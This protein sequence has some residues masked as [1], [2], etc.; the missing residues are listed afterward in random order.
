MSDYVLCIWSSS[1]ANGR[2]NLLFG[3]DTQTWGFKNFEPDYAEPNRW[4]LFGHDHSNGSP[5]LDAVAWQAGTVD[6][7]LCEFTTP[8]YRGQA[9]HWPDEVEAGEVIYPHRFG[10]TPVASIA[11]TPAAP[12]ALL[13]AAGTEALRLAAI[14]NRGV[15][16]DID[17][18]PLLAA[19]GVQVVGN[20]VPDLSRTAGVPRP[21]FPPVRGKRGLGRSHDPEFNSAVERRAVE[22]AT[23][24]LLAQGW[25][26]V[27]PLGKP[28]DL[29]CTKRTGEEKHVEVKGASGAG[30]DVQY[31]PNEVRHFRTCPHGADLIVVRD[32]AVD[33]DVR[34]YV[35][36]GGQLLHVENYTAPAEDLQA[37][38]WLGRVP[39][40][41][42]VDDTGEELT[43]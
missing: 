3:L 11:G 21:A 7:V 31:T 29:V 13:G 26:E 2:R 35:A 33:R 39:G 27:R 42:D 41:G 15:R 10:L 36:T 38:G 30:A 9:P 19:M 37:T 34:P 4:V 43:A 17:V 24:H 14:G 28:F 16:V 8:L 18:H 40:W 25:D 1:S 22:M 5:R 6:L 12:T 32:I 20:S 23:E